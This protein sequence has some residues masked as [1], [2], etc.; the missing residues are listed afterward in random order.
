MLIL[1]RIKIAGFFSYLEPIEVEFGPLLEA[2]FFG[3]LGPT[4][5]GKSALLDCILIALFNKSA[6][7]QPSPNSVLNPRADYACIELEFALGPQKYRVVYEKKKQGAQDS[8]VPSYAL[9]DA[10]SLQTLARG[11]EVFQ[12]ISEIIGMDYDHF[13]QAFLLEQGQFQRFLHSSPSQRAE[14][15]AS[16]LKLEVLSD[17]QEVTS[18]L[19][20]EA[21]GQ[22]EQLQEQK[23]QLESQTSPERQNQIEEEIKRLENQ[24]KEI[25]E[26]IKA[27]REE[28]K[29]MDDQQKQWNQLKETR[30]KLKELQNQQPRYEEKQQKLAKTRLVLEKMGTLFHDEKKYQNEV[31]RLRNEIQPLEQK[32]NEILSKLSSLR[33]RIEELESLHRNKSEYERRKEQ[34][35]HLRAYNRLQKEI[36]DLRKRQEALQEKL[37]EY[38]KR[39]ESLEQ[40]EERL[41]D[42]TK[43][44]ES[45]LRALSPELLVLCS[46]WEESFQKQEEAKKECKDRERELQNQRQAL[47]RA[48]ESLIGFC[49]QVGV[50]V[51]SAEASAQVWDQTLLALASKLEEALQ[52]E[53]ERLNHAKWAAEL[54]A[55]L[56]ENEPCPVCGSPHHPAPASPLPSDSASQEEFLQKAQAHLKNLR[57]TYLPQLFSLE[58]RLETAKKNLSQISEKLK[59]TESKLQEK[60][61]RSPGVG[62]YAELESLQKNRQHKKDEIE[63]KLSDNQNAQKEVNGAIQQQID[64]LNN[65]SQKISELKGKAE[66]YRSQLPQ[67]MVGWSEEEAAKREK[68]VEDALRKIEEYPGLDAQ[69]KKLEGD[70]SNL[71]GQ[72]T[73]KRNNLERYKAELERLTSQ[74]QEE[75]KK[76]GLELAEARKLYEESAAYDLQKEEQEMRAFFEE[77]RRTQEREKE[78]ESALQGYDETKHQQKRKELEEKEKEK[79]RLSGE[80]GWYQAQLEQL[81]E[82]Q[83]KLKKVK[84]DL[85]EV[86]RRYLALDELESLLR[87]KMFMQFVLRR[88]LERI[89]RS[90]NEY[91]VQ[92]NGGF[93]E[94]AL[95]E[96]KAGSFKGKGG[97]PKERVGAGEAGES[98]SDGSAGGEGVELEVEVVDYGGGEAVRRSV[99]T[100]SGGQTFQASLAL[101]LALSERIVAQTRGEG[102]PGFFII[103]EGF[104]SLDQESLEQVVSTLRQLGRSK[105]AIGVITHREELKEHLQ[106]YLQVE[107]AQKGEDKRTSRIR[108][109]WEV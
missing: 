8:Y 32:L 43:K 90:A 109:S 2:G 36:E 70:I 19:K 86:E 89:L 83:E 105:R 63:R 29:Q 64:Q 62:L 71:E 85:E 103:D 102:R 44:L 38:K 53:R 94:L 100:L 58:A 99:K 33:P 5:A 52:L 54:A 27:L 20:A 18:R 48:F 72:L 35:Q 4:G 11:R 73:E 3:I 21:K 9:L 76:Q 96:K 28:V 91:L 106:A 108:P 1:N 57:T 81:R 25:E 75:A 79:E 7:T 88:Y 34:I 51:P 97:A 59:E 60:F 47:H 30:N 92:W 61:S 31:G 17:L 104:G 49:Q 74:L 56:R 68:E 107:L 66:A 50:A 87:G 84:Q 55:H 24:R 95:S 41:K 16:L 14:V 15:L 80:Q 93:W 39:K 69:A 67:E 78:L 26:S 101:A 37:A 98:P 40:E 13:T 77:L 45:E 12:K 10:N 22:G 65:Y 23:K 46:Q 6:R 42:E 82:N